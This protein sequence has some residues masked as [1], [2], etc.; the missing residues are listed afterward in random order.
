MVLRIKTTKN[1]Y[2]PADDSFL[3]AKYAKKLKGRILEIGCGAGIVS[4]ECAAAEPHNFVEGV[5]V[6]KEAVKLARENAKNNGIKNAKFYKSDLFSN[7]RGKFDCIIFNPPYLPTA[8]KDKIHGELNAAFDGGADGLEIITKF[9]FR[10][11]RY[12]KERGCIYIIASSLAD[13]DKVIKLFN[14]NGFKANVIEEQSFFFEKI[15]LLKATKR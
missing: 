9:I 3:L 10:A 11:G 1:V 15:A 6:N 12:L 13:I 4:L 8:H 2:E 5:D 7:V 14:K